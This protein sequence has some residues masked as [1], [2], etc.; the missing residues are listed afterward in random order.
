MCSELKYRFHYFLHQMPVGDYRNA[1]KTIPQIL[2]ISAETWRKWI[3]IK[4]DEK[5]EIRSD[6]ALKL[7][8]FF[9]CNL[10][11]LYSNPPAVISYYELNTKL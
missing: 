1:M 5:R 6:C 11:E 10:D 3:Y 2:G 9:E 7:C 4:D 8:E